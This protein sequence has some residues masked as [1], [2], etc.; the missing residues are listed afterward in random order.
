MTN[1]LLG[2][3]LL[4]VIHRQDGMVARAQLL[5][6]GLSDNDV[7]VLLRGPTLHPA[8]RGVYCTSSGEPT[9]RQRVWLGTLRYAPA[10]ASGKTCLALGGLVPP[11]ATVE[12]AVD[13][14]RRVGGEAG[15]VVRRSRSFRR[16]AVLDAHPPRM[17]LEPAVLD[18]LAG[19]DETRQI[20][21]LGD[22]LRSRRTTGERLRDE[23]ATRARFPGRDRVAALLDDAAG[24]AQSVLEHRY[25][26]DVERAHG[27]PR[28]CRQVRAELEGKSIYRDAVYLDGRLV[29]ELDGRQGHEDSRDRWADAERDL[30]TL[31]GGGCTVRLTYGQVV[32]P[33]RTAALV[34]RVLAELGW[35]GK[36]SPC[37]VRCRVGA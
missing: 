15:V 19:L 8:A 13:A 36:P 1:P 23:L 20:A 9:W 12:V 10:V 5:E 37:S 2:P 4:A 34:A 30:N 25:L 29:I 33:C 28:A 18:V 26:R 32:D 3:A 21:L 27:L 24:G 14:S 16:H 11:P 31:V 35:T 22:V 17:R 7:E 6:A